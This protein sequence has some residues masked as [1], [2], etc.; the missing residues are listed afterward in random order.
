M[1]VY[2]KMSDIMKELALASFRD[3]QTV[4]SSEAAHAALLLAHVA[5]NR[6]L[7]H[8]IQ[9]YRKLFK[10][11]LRSNPNLWSEFCSRDTE[12]I[13]ETMCKAKE[14]SYH[15]DRRVVVVCGMREGNVHVEWCEEKD[16]PEASTQAKKRLDSEYGTGRTIGKRRSPKGA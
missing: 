15:T 8:D 5:W 10:V 11:F 2:P 16:Y 6:A 12:T 4:P 3:S 7:G 9:D 13:I 1:T 14:K